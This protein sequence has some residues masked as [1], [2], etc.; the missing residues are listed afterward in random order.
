MVGGLNDLLASERGVFALALAIG[1][2]IFVY[3]DKMTIQQW[4]DFNQWL[5][6]AL[7]GSKTVTTAMEIY[8]NRPK[9]PPVPAAAPAPPTMITTVAVAEPSK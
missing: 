4:V 3:L 6:T 5:S 2:S 1:S 8:A 9:A 7:I